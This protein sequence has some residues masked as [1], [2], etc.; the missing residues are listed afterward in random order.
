MLLRKKTLSKAK[1]LNTITSKIFNNNKKL[2]N[3]F[4]YSN[5]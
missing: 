1:L 2:F 4:R 3:Y 5:Y